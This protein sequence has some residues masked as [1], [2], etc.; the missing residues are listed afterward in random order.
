[1][2]KMTSSQHFVAA[3][4]SA[5]ME[6]SFNSKENVKI[7]HD[8]LDSYSMS[9]FKKEVRLKEFLDH[10]EKEEYP[11]ISLL[12]FGTVVGNSPG[13]RTDLMIPSFFR[14]AYTV[15]RLEVGGH[16]TMRSFL[17]L[18]DLSNAIHTLISKTNK[19][20]LTQTDTSSR[21]NIWHLS[22]FD[23]TVFKVAS[24]VASLT[25]ATIDSYP[26]DKK[27]SPLISSQSGFSL[28]STAFE[29]H[30]SFTFEDSLLTAIR[31]FDRNVPDSIIPKGP[32]QVHIKEDKDTIPCPVCGSTGQQV[33]LDLGLQ[34]LANGF[35]SDKVIAVSKPRF[36][37][38]LVRCRV[39]NHY[40][41]SHVVDRGDLFEHYLYQSGTSST[42][43][44]YFE[45]LAR[46]VIEESNLGDAPGSILEIAC[47]DGS[48]LD[49]YLKH[50]WKTFGVD[51]AANLAAIAAR[52]HTVH[53]GFWPLHFPELP[54]GDDLTAITAQNVAAHVP[55]VVAF[56]KGCADVMGSKTKLYIQTSQ[57]NM[58]R[59]GQ[60]DTVYHEHISFFTGHSFQKAAE[61]SGLQVISFETTPIHG[62]SCLVTMQL[63]DVISEQRLRERSIDVP[64]ISPTLKDRLD[65]EKNDGITSDFFAMKFSSH[66][67]S[68]REWTR[69]EL[70]QFKSKGYT[71]GGYGAAVTGM[72]LLHY[73]IGEN[74]DGSSYLDFVLDDAELKQ[75]TYCPG[76][77][78]H[79][80]PTKSLL[81]LTDPEKPLAILI[82]EWNFFDEIAKKIV[83]VL[84]E[85]SHKG[86]TFLVPFPEPRVIYI[87]LMEAEIRHQLLRKLLHYPT[88]IPNPITNDENRIK[89]F[90]VAHQ[91][92]EELLMPFFIMNHASMFDKVI[93]IDYISDDHTLDLVERFAPPSWE[94]VNSTTGMSFD[95]EKCDDQM[96]FYEKQNPRHWHLA[97]TITEFL[98]APNFRQNLARVTKGR[99][100]KG[101][102]VC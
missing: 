28:D 83:S 26:S 46:K 12:R 38:K 33:V 102:N 52:K 59:L 29:K 20:R 54:K 77:V 75:N 94:I 71:V 57:C 47:N 1:M 15:G 58:Q 10:D 45:W 73:I 49:H 68:I 41:L 69:N 4:T 76:T 99:D 30:F 65:K 14:S 16:N 91:R 64:V 85:S 89:T 40:H 39:C 101:Q 56:L 87:D 92:N 63:N 93:L 19:M 82:F 84:K 81:Q 100:R 79:V 25:G 80:H 6:G 22:S 88:P 18:R 98:V 36:P 32:H 96:M 62:E 78:I 50:G 48:Q 9:M 74:N 67:N 43:S 27:L 72:V 66:A 97:L 11:K 44:D 24:T 34:P 61:L 31:D 51:P 70:L 86:V 5:I 95:L 3:S 90:M 8:L 23:A 17:T 37:L 53:I 42:I 60:F 21:F 2:K 35:S 7:K 13:Q 55:D